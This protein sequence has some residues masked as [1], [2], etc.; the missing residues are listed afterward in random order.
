[1]ATWGRRVG[2]PDYLPVA[3]GGA[4]QVVPGVLDRVR[5]HVPGLA[6]V[7]AGPVLAQLRLDLAPRPA[8]PAPARVLVVAVAVHRLV[9]LPAARRPVVGL[10][11]LPEARH[12]AVPVLAR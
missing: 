5:R 9:L 8:A 12:V 11:V 1:M 7:A 2:A 4:G 6:R 10:P 3:V